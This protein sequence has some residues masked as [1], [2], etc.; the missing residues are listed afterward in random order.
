M[1]EVIWSLLLSLPVPGK[2]LSPGRL[3]VLN[4][5]NHTNILGLILRVDVKSKRRMFK[6]LLS[7]DTQRFVYA[8]S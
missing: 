6:V 8:G 2:A 3:V 4:Y 5:E 7:L 1:R